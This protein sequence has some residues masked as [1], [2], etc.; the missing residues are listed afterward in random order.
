MILVHRSSFMSLRNAALEIFYES[1]EAVNPRVAVSRAVKM[2]RDSLQVFDHTF[3]VSGITS[4]ISVSTGKAGVSMA[5]GLSDSI[6]GLLT[7]GIVS[8]P[9]SAMPVPI[10]WRVYTGGHPV[11]NDASMKAAQAALDLLDQNNR[12]TTLFIFLISGGG[13]SM[14]ELPADSILSLS[15]LQETNRIL[16][17]CGASIAEINAIR[18]RL[19]KVKGGGLAAAA[20]NGQQIT[21]IVSDTG[22]GDAKN[23][24]S[25]PTIFPEDDIDVADVIRRYG[26]EDKLPPGVVQ[27]CFEDRSVRFQSSAVKRNK[28]F[29]LLENRDALRAA[30][31][32]AERRGFVTFV[33]S[34]T[35]DEEIE[36][37][38]RRLLDQFEMLHAASE[39]KP[40]ALI[41][42]GEY[43]CPVKGDGIGGRNSEATMR[44]LIEMANRRV[45]FPFAVL[46]AGTDGVDGNSRAAGAV[47]DNASLER[48]I[49][50]KVDLRNYLDRSDTAA[51]FEKSGDLIVTGPTGTNVRDVRVLVAGRSESG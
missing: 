43:R 27:R 32:A 24:A 3:P 8:A 21:L 2:A 6:G 35:E 46:N 22:V 39:G 20:S 49:R 9:E 18:R 11:P 10:P 7:A 51:F 26:L 38:C 37:G 33:D 30:E 13:S 31:R 19:S 14:F 50:D 48:A 34:E 40:V 4:V 1:L 15:Q 41:S 47:V 5:T 29:T 45:H 36:A 42:G 44:C 12:E 25:G 28:V 17:N 23:V 16:V